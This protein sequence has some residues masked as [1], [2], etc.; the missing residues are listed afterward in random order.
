LIDLSSDGLG[1]RI[2]ATLEPGDRIRIEDPSLPHLDGA[3]LVIVRRDPRD[4]QRHGAR[5]VTPNRGAGTLATMLGL[6]RAERA[7]RRRLQIDAIRRS[8]SA[9]AVPVTSE[10]AQELTS[11]RMSTRRRAGGR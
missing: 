1:F 7:H 4:A 11:P 5:F 3:E 10:D 9:T 2:N 6:D 8:G